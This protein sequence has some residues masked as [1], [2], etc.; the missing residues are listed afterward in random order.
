MKRWTSALVV[1]MLAVVAAPAV[2]AQTP[3]AG[4]ATPPTAAATPPAVAGPDS[5]ISDSL[6]QVAAVAAD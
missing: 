3:P 6:R 1:C 4:S 2:R 5:T